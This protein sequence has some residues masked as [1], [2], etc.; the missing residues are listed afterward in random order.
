MPATMA[1]LSMYAVLAVDAGNQSAG[2]EDQSAPAAMSH[3]FSFI[4]QKPS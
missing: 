1:P 2:F 3:W 4:S